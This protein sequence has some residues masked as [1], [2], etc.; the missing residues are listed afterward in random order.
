VSALPASPADRPL[1][2]ADVMTAPLATVREMDDILDALAAMR[3]HGVRRLPV[4]NADGALRGIVAIDN[5]LEAMAEQLDAVV[6]VI[7]AGQSKETTLRR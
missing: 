4:V 1:T 6:G 2:A 7:K 5:L 3:G